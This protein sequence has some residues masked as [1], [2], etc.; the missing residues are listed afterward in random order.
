MQ[1]RTTPDPT[2]APAAKADPPYYPGPRHC[3]RCK[4]AVKVRANTPTKT[5]GEGRVWVWC[6]KCWYV[7]GAA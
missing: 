1:E 5:D 3:G 6:N 4:K 7:K 2:P